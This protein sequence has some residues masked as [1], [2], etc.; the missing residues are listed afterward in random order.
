MDLLST[1]EQ[2]V[3]LQVARES[4]I[5]CTTR[6][7]LPTVQIESSRLNEK[8]GCFVCIKIGGALKGCLGNFISDKPLYHLV[9][10]MAEAA[11]CRDPRFYPMKPADLEDFELEI[12]VLTPMQKI[13]S[14]DEIEVGTHGLYIEK[15]GFRGVLLPQVATEYGWN[16]ET[17][18]GQ[19]CLK[20]GLKKT[21]W[22]EG[23]EIYIFSAQVFGDKSKG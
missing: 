7:P 22:Q 23:A 18:L 3:L 1:D 10:E 16:L 14:T 19:T 8:R 6:Q 15:N 11:S 13:A 12:S 4:V 2:N 20:A 5:A 9:Q 17:F 21:D